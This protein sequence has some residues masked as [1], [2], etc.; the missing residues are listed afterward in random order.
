MN[1][2]EKKFLTQKMDPNYL[3]NGGQ[4]FMT[5]VNFN[6]KLSHQFSRKNIKYEKQ[7]ITKK[8]RN[9]NNWQ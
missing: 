9:K 7:G 5:R 8:S 2:M 1:G 3:Y 6:V 4:A